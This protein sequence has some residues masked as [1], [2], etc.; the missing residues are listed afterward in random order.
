MQAAT[1]TRRV[2][3][4]IFIAATP[5]T[6]WQLLVDPSH[7]IQW[8]GLRAAVELQPGGRYRIEV[9]PG[10][11]ATGEFVEID[12][13]R[14]LVYTWG[15]DRTESAVPPGSTTVTFELTASGNGTLLSLRHDDLPTVEAA[16]SH[17]RGW[18][19][20][21]ARLTVAASG[22]PGPDPWI[23]GATS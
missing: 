13:L 22:D 1:E 15:W 12:P 9:I 23:S 3:R 8:M 7:I 11:I 6:V 5:E 16:A 20:Y 10:Q 19:H 4:T 17:T 2:E 14:R 18:N 21:L